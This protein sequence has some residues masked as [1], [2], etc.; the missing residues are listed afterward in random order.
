MLEIGGAVL[1]LPGVVDHRRRAAALAAA[2]IT[3][4]PTSPTSGVVVWARF[5]LGPRPFDAVIERRARRV[6]ARAA[7]ASRAPLRRDFAAE[8]RQLER[9]AAGVG[10]APD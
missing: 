2:A 3:A 7:A 4:R 9:I 8:L 1:R 5:H 6:V 10:T